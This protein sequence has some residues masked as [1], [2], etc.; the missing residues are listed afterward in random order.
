MDYF[1]P[2]NFRSSTQFLL[3]AFRVLKYF[4]IPCY[5]IIGPFGTRSFSVFGS[6]SVTGIYGI[7]IFSVVESFGK[8]SFLVID[9]FKMHANAM[10]RELKHGGIA[11]SRK[12]QQKRATKDKERKRQKRQKK[13]QEKTRKVRAERLKEKRRKTAEKKQKTKR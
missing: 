6:L 2:L 8:G 5:S 10:L 3:A 9:I 13:K 12:G 7:P 11:F 1:E 4:C